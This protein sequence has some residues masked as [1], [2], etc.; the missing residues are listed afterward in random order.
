MTSHKAKLIMTRNQKNK[1]E[2]KN[3]LQKL[4]N[5]L[6]GHTGYARQISEDLQA[7]GL[8]VSENMVYLAVKTGKGRFYEDIA[9][10]VADYVTKNVARQKQKADL[11]TKRVQEAMDA[12]EG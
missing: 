1:P 12:V 5:R 7:K 2:N 11:A 3:N 8:S 9:I 10:E 6:D 4:I